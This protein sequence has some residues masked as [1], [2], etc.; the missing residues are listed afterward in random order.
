M[1]T[2]IVVFFLVASV[3]A[4]CHANPSFPGVGHPLL[5]ESAV[6]S[7]TSGD[8]HDSFGS[9]GHESEHAHLEDDDS[10]GS[11][12]QKRLIGFGKYNQAV[13]TPFETLPVD[14]LIDTFFYFGRLQEERLLWWL[15]RVS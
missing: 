9:P 11:V 1:K 15:W 10:E 4:I 3:I 7:G 5:A 6:A 13:S 8:L 14:I 12:R 2:I